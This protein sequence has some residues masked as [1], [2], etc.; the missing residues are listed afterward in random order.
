M[1]SQIIDFTYF[2]TIIAWIKKKKKRDKFVKQLSSPSKVYNA[3]VID[4]TN[5]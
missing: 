4:G 3:G 1:Y 5:P 2:I